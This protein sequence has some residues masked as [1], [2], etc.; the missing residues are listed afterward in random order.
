MPSSWEWRIV[1]RA[2]PL[3]HVARATGL[4]SAFVIVIAAVAVARW[5]TNPDALT[6]GDVAGDFR[7]FYHA[8]DLVRSGLSDH[9]YDRLHAVCHGAAPEPPFMHPPIVALGFVPLTLVGYGPALLLFWAGSLASLWLSSRLASRELG[10]LSTARGLWLAL[11]FAPLAYSLAYGQLTAY[12]ALPLVGFVVSLRRSREVAAGL[13]LAGILDGRGSG[14]GESSTVYGASADG[15]ARSRSRPSRISARGRHAHGDLARIRPRCAR[16][17][18]RHEVGFDD[19]KIET[20]ERYAQPLEPLKQGDH[21]I[22]NW[23]GALRS[24]R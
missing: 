6:E 9:L 4:S 16:R 3:L 11:R 20:R 1:A 2:A 18:S 13:C 21:T 15:P 5:L 23:R 8:G 12:L 24:H 7:G 17:R 19:Y 10:D 14:H 22:T